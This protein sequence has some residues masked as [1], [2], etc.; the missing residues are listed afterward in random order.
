[1]GQNFNDFSIFQYIVEHKQKYFSYAIA[2][3]LNTI[4]IKSNYEVN[5]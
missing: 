5:N 2:N 4:W 1:M 3:N